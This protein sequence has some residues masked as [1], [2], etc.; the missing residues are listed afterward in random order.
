ML[1]SKVQFEEFFSDSTIWK[2]LKQE[3]FTWLGDI[4]IQLENNSGELSSRVLDRL[5]GNAEALRNIMDI[6]QAIMT[7]YDTEPNDL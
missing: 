6:E 7:N 5:G 2:D 3:L 4:H 1:T